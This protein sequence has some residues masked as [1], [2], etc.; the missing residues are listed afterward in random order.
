MST[1]LKNKIITCIGF[2]I[3]ALSYI[4]PKEAVRLTEK[5][6]SE[7]KRGKLNR[8]EL[9]SILE[10]SDK[11]QLPYKD[12]LIQTYTWKGD[13]K[14]ILLVHGWESNASRWQRLIGI[15]KKTGHTIIALDAPAHGLSG[16][17]WFNVAKYAECLKVV[18]EHF[19]PTIIV[20]HSIGGTASM[21]HQYQYETPSVKK[22]ILLGS[23]GELEILVANF[24]K[25]LGLKNRIIRLTE[26]KFIKDYNIS[27]KD[28]SIAKMTPF[29]KSK[30][31]IA[32]DR[33][34]EVVK[35]RESRKIAAAWDDV[36]FVQ[37]KGLGHG[38][39]DEELYQKIY[40]FVLQN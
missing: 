7:P 8:N 20:G 26:K 12:T 24:A 17:K 29:I 39:Q 21:Y 40:E 13:E 18:I 19:N 30:G 3:N 28:F 4:F 23:P 6:I 34:D 37:T 15:L 2:Y 16:G 9:P 31:F 22:I 11:I 38:L 33:K 32:H 10:E 36:I 35:I 5:Y 27:F 14:I 25:I 1:P